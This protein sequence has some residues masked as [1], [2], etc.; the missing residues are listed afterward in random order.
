MIKFILLIPIFFRFSIYLDIFSELI[1]FPSKSKR[2]L[3][4]LDFEIC[5]NISKLSFSIEIF[6]LS[7]FQQILI[8]LGEK[9]DQH[10]DDI[11]LIG[12]NV[13]E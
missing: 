11:D 13:E 6:I 9:E 10:T 5:F 7:L 3:Y 1:S 8:H 4:E 2:I 12:K